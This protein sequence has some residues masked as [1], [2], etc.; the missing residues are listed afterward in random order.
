MAVRTGRRFKLSRAAVV[1]VAQT[2]VAARAAPRVV[3]HLAPIVAWAAASIA[4]GLVVGLAAVALPPL[5]AFGIVAVVGLVLLWVM[6]DLPLVWPGLIRRTFFVMLIAELCVPG[7]YMIQFA[8]LP[9]MSLRRLATLMLIAPFVLAIAASSDV[10]RQ[11]AERVRASLLMCICAVGYLVMA[12]LSIFTSAIPSESFSA[13]IEAILAW[14]LPFFAMIYI[15]KNKYD[16]V[17]ILKIICFGALFNSIAG[18]LEFSFQH[19]FFLDVF[20]RGMLSALIETN[21]ALQN[22]L[23]SPNDFRN[24]LYRSPSIFLSPLSYGEFNIIVIP[25]ALFFALQRQNWFERGLGWAVVIGG[26]LGIFCS[27][28]RGGWVGVLASVAVFV[29][30]WSIRKAVNDRG[31]LGPAIAGLIGVVS[32]TVVIG[33]IIVWPKAHN[34]VLGGGAEAGSTQSRYIQWV[35]ALPFIRSN[36]ITGHGFVLGGEVIKGSIDSYVISLLV[37]TGLPGLAF[38]GGMLL[39]PIW[40]GLRSYLSDMSETGA[41]AGALACSFIAFT[42]NRLVLSERENHTLIFSLLAI[43]VYL[44]YE[45]AKERVTE[46]GSSRLGVRTSARIHGGIGQPVS[47]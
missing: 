33:L 38:F 22:L 11:I 16:I 15:I 26:L 24:G 35:V 44:N 17:F 4:L 2:K 6:P 42:T 46:R 18:V 27:G 19:R 32:F 12:S 20:P 40:Y 10:R 9:W 14:Y 37:E 41:V 45:Y 25:I 43:I 39:L 36:P 47:P 28:S 8:G 3:R 21:P 13:L 23:P 31:S 34:M 29:T 7:Y 1:A 30:I 5:G